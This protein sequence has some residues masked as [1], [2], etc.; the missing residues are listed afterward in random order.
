ME[1]C[2]TFV[3]R[4]IADGASHTAMDVGSTSARVRALGRVMVACKIT[5]Y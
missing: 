4:Q 3:I 5:P 2:L 1:N